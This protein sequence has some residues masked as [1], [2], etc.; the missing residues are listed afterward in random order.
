MTGG[1]RVLF[2]AEAV[3][4]AHVARPLV[5]ARS[6]LSAGHLPVM[7][8][9]DRYKRFLDQEQWETLPLNSISSAQ[10]M[11]HLALGKPVYDI[12][13][14]RS[15]VQQD[16]QL[17]DRV[18]PDLIVGDFRLSLSVSARLA[19]VPYATITNAYWSPFYSNRSLPLPVLPLSRALP[20]P[21]ARKLFDVF[22]P[23]AFELHCRPMNQLRQENGLP[24]L[25]ADI[26]RV[27]T[28]ADYTL[29]ADCPDM[30]AME[31]MPVTHR[32]L[33]PILWSPPVDVPVWWQRLPADKPLVYLT[34]G[35][36]GSAAVMQNVLDA[37]LDIPVAVIVSTAGAP[38]PSNSSPDL[39]AADYLP[40]CEA[41]ARAS[42][43]ICNGG[44]P[45]SQ[46]ALAGGVPVLGVVSNMDQ[47]MNMA[48]VARWNAGEMLRADRV[49]SRKVQ[50]AV[51]RL[52]KLPDSR[53]GAQN[54]ARAF[55]TFDCAQQF[56]QFITDLFAGKAATPNAPAVP[57]TS[58]S[59]HG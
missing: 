48:A 40:G 7:A 55:R 30:F 58:A 12:G 57:E 49:R 1:K 20:L 8:C 19:G 53:R 31:P 43:V 38:L 6:L 13:T 14:L 37:L 29:Y 51:N 5:L 24:P 39:F 45:T 27:Y 28:E 32:F 23:W 4:L 16:L 52:I 15:Y 42:L 47:F 54:L 33:G 2:F 46:Q 22:S 10:F 17:I 21:V 35:S 3:T 36:S 34:L 59:L 9:H 25:G 56:C 41:A 18:K 50:E 44:S 26:R 11:H